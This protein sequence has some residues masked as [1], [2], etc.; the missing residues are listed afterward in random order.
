MTFYEAVIEHWKK[1]FE[2]SGTANNKEYWCPVIFDV[3]IAVIAFAFTIFYALTDVTAFGVL[4]RVMCIFLAVSMIPFMSLTVRRLHETGKSGWWSCLLFVVGIGTLIVIYMCI[5]SAS[6]SFDPELNYV[7]EVYGPPE[8]FEFE[9]EALEDSGMENEIGPAGVDD[10]TDDSQEN[11][12]VVPGENAENDNNAGYNNVEIEEIFDPVE[13][14]QEEVYGPPA[15]MEEDYEGII[16]DVVEDDDDFDPK[17]NTNS[18]VYGPPDMLE[19]YGSELI[20]DGNVNTG[21][22]SNGSII[23]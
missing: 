18:L 2:Y 17:C 9:D 7:M 19:N 12:N 15:I 3:I 11:I 4:A 16:V 8:V 22:N 23:Q 21:N 13:N 20:D 6:A 1:I 10:I 5:G 14:I